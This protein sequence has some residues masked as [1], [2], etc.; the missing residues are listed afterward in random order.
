MVDFNVGHKANRKVVPRDVD[1]M[2]DLGIHRFEIAVEHALGRRGCK[3]HGRSPI[4]HSR[5]DGDR[6]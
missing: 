6:E 3:G 2:L 5:A 1:R 4:A